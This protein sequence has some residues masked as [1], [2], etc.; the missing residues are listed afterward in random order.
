MKKVNIITTRKYFIKHH[1]KEKI[2][3]VKGENK[4]SIGLNQTNID[5][6]KQ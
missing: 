5:K 2:I 4:E 3:D 6:K 1:E